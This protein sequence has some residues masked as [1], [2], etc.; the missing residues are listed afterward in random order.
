VTDFSARD[1]S[2]GG[3]TFFPADWLAAEELKA[4]SFAAKGLWIG[5]VCLM[6]RSPKFG[7]LLRPNGEKP[8]ST[9]I[10]KQLGGMALEVEALMEELQKERVYSIEDGAVICRRMWRKTALSETRA[11]A[12]L[13]GASSRW[14]KDGK[15][16]KGDGKSMATV[17]KERKG[18]SCSSSSSSSS[19]VNDVVNEWN[20]LGRPFGRVLRIGARE[21]HLR[22]RLS[23]PWWCENWRSA[24]EKMKTIPGLRG[25]NDREWVADIDFFLRPDTVAKILEGKYDNWKPREDLHGTGKSRRGVEEVPYARKG[26][27]IR[28]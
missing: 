16:R 8:D 15:R 13:Q 26:E 6:A 4:V 1:D 23:D 18:G 11:E 7:M 9:W 2:R 25:E 28:L 17:G 19:S 5:L 12:G 20:L 21:S 14:Q 22:N 10:A 3:F 27:S 24:L